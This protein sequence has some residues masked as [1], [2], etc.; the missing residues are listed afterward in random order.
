MINEEVRKLYDELMNPTEALSKDDFL[1]KLIKIRNISKYSIYH[2]LLSYT[3]KNELKELIKWYSKEDVGKQMDIKENLERESLNRLIWEKI[4]ILEIFEKYKDCI[5]KV[6]LENTS[7]DE[8][9]S[10]LKVTYDYIDWVI[11]PPEWDT[12]IQPWS[13]K[14]LNKKEWYDRISLLFNKILNIEN[15]IYLWDFRVVIGKD[16]NNSLRKYS[17]VVIEIPKLNKSIFVNNKYGEATYIYDWIP[18]DKDLLTK[19]KESL[20]TVCTKIS[21]YNA[22]Q[23]EKQV[24]EFLFKE[25]SSDK[26]TTFKDI[27]AKDLKN[28]LDM[29]EKKAVIRTILNEKQ[30][31]EKRFS[32]NTDQR[33]HFRL[34]DWTS[35]IIIARIFGFTERWNHLIKD[36]NF[37]ELSKKIFG[38]DDP[39]VIKLINWCVIHTTDSI[40]NLFENNKQL[41]QLR[42]SLDYFHR[43]YFKLPDKTSYLIIARTFGFKE[44]KKDLSK[45][46]FFIELSKKIFGENDPDVIKLINKNT[47]HTINSIRNLLKD[48]KELKEKR[49]SLLNYHDKEKFKLSNNTTY[50]IISRIFWFNEEKKVIYNNKTFIELSKKIFG[51]DDPDVIK[52]KSTVHTINSIRSL[53]KD[54][55]ELKEKRFSLSNYD[56]RTMFKLPD[57]TS[58]LTIARIFGFKEGLKDLAKDKIFIE[59]SKKIFGEDDPDVIN[60]TNNHMIYA[61]SIKALLTNDNQLKKLRFSLNIKQRINFKLSNYTSYTDIARIFGFTENYKLLAKDKIFTELSKKIFWENDPDVIKLCDK[62]TVHTVSSIRTIFENNAKL[63]EEWFHLKVEQRNWFKLPNWTSYLTIAR[64]F[65]FSETRNELQRNKRFLELSKRIFGENDPDVIQLAKRLNK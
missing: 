46:K 43:F 18:T 8:K 56:D 15:N 17:Y 36:K 29:E 60:Y 58:Y 61:D 30:T 59:L 38:E 65:N 64:I 55:K 27:K 26:S 22:D 7:L 53:F 21:F 3:N 57:K 12:R 35:Y 52:L 50:L 37:I 14:W 34:D 31:K 2:E 39:D 20:G 11:F 16:D 5:K 54:N 9:L 47:E 32:L 13:W 51:E 42:F 62:Y 33:L 10:S 49:F 44:E 40:R 45:N 23:W 19:W 24:S 1:E 28:V 25:N 4:S 48:N 6:F 63:K 41:K